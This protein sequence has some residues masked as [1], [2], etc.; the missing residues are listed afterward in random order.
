MKP[1][2]SRE[3]IVEIDTLRGA[4][5]GGVLLVNLV[6]G[7][8]VPLS[9]HILGQD[10]PLGPAGSVLLALMDSL[11]EFKAFTLFSF[12]FGVGIAIQSERAGQDQRTPFLLRRFGA[13]LVLGLVHLFLIWNGDILALYGVCGLLIVP[14]LR[15][16]AHTLAALGLIA[17][18]AQYLVSLPVPFP[19]NAAL[20]ALSSGAVH[21]YRSGGWQELLAFRWHETQLLILPLLLLSMPRTFGLMLWGVA[22]WRLGLFENNRRLLRWILFLGLAAG[23]TAA[24][25]RSGQV[26]IIPL[27]FAYGAAILLWKPHA[28]W[29]AAAGRTALTNYLAQSVVFAFVFYGY[30]LALFSTL[31]VGVTMAGGIVFYCLQLGFSAWWLRRFHFGPLEWLWRCI[32]YLRW[33]PFLRDAARFVTRGTVRL[34]LLA[35]FTLGIPAVHLGIPFLLARV[36]PRWGWK[37]GM[38]QPLNLLGLLVILAGAGLLLWVLLTMLRAVSSLPPLCRLGLRPAMLLQT[39]PFARMRHPIYLAEACFW[40]GLTLLLGSPVLAVLFACLA[41]AV[42]GWLIPHEE[43]A[44]EEQFGDEYRAY[45][46]RVPALPALRRPN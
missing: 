1:A 31:G 38:P 42:P 3:R 44:L 30:G 35:V 18:G 9:A 14:L 46:I 34:L 8:R 4:A 5:L 2:S 29:L 27:A 39:G 21:A 41:L 28:P 22:A 11:L 37:D 7:F 15:L 12:L 17:I 40:A 16:P 26:A 6:S 43:L 10:E 20:L 13:L 33:Q 36:G 25:L 24:I 19:D 23:I 45:R 32:S